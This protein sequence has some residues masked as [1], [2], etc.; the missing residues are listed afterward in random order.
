MGGSYCNNHMLLLRSFQ[1]VR[2]IVPG[3]VFTAH[4]HHLGPMLQN[5]VQW[6]HNVRKWPK[7]GRGRRQGEPLCTLQHNRGLAGCRIVTKLRHQSE[8]CSDA[9]GSSIPWPSHE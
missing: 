2:T 5:S 8:G 6:W 1:R 3:G 4:S 9:V 7:T